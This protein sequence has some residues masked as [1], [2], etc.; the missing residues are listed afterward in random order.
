MYVICYLFIKH[1]Y[2]YTLYIN[3]LYN[4]GFIILYLI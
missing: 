2:M 4:T 1:T 3:Q